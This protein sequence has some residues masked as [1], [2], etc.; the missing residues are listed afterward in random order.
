MSLFNIFVAQIISSCTNY[1]IL[2]AIIIC[3]KIFGKIT[4]FLYAVATHARMVSCF[5]DF[6]FK[7]KSIILFMYCLCC[8]VVYICGDMFPP[9]MPHVDV[10]VRDVTT[11]RN[12]KVPD[13]HDIQIRVCL[14]NSVF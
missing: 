8:W 5:Y 9:T 10:I 14:K 4:A 2:L 6:Y 11:G 13:L 12:S 7:I 1:F 3:S